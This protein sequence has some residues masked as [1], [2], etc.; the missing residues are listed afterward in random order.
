MDINK[1]SGE[2][3]VALMA[4]RRSHPRLE[5]P[6]P[7]DELMHSLFT[8]SLRAPDHMHLRPWRFLT[9]AGTDREFLGDLFAK[10]FKSNN[11]NADAISL[12]S[13][14]KK[15]LRAPLIVVGIASYKDH[16][17]VPKIEQS[18]AAAGVLHNIGM[19][20]YASGFG[21]VWRTGPY[22]SSA[23]V[24][25]GL[26]LTEGEEIVGYLYVGTP[27]KAD[28]PLKPISSEDFF[29]AWPGIK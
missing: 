18:I 2:Q 27:S 29:S 24:K 9:I 1:Q 6:A 13:A 10:D 14:A 22:A 26:G 3:I 11:S 8:A 20:V 4:Q 21:S 19:A 23:I 7:S 17:R 25:Q 15:A 12:E 5:D 16:D 28:R